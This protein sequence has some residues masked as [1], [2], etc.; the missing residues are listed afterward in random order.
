MVPRRITGHRDSGMQS[1]G[2]GRKPG[3]RRAASRPARHSGPDLGV[4][5]PRFQRVPTLPL[6]LVRLSRSPRRRSRVHPSDAAARGANSGANPADAEADHG[7]THRRAA[8]HPRSPQL[9]LPHPSPAIRPPLHEARR[10][11]QRLLLPAH[12]AEGSLPREVE[13]ARVPL[14]RARDAA[15]RP[16]RSGEQLLV[17]HQRLAHASPSRRP[18]R[19]LR[20]PLRHA[21]GPATRTIRAA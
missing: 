3:V 16:R 13:Y 20:R 21:R 4:L 12:H 2:C 15:E 11:A 19:P 18:P 14:H 7:E 9:R 10:V 8:Q 5:L 17:R 6:R 1:R